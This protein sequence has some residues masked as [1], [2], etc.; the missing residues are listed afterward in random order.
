[1]VRRQAIENELRAKMAGYNAKCR[2]K[3]HMITAASAATATVPKHTKVM[4]KYNGAG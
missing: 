3:N 2:D 1:M 4:F